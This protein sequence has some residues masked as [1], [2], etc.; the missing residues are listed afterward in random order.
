MQLYQN[1]NNCLE[2]TFDGLI[3]LIKQRLGLSN[4]E[5]TTNDRVRE[6]MQR[7]GKD[8]YPLSWLIIQELRAWRENASGHNIARHGWTSPQSYTES[9]A[10]KAY[11][12]P[13]QLGVELHIAHNDP[14]MILTY[15][16][17]LMIMGMTN[18]LNFQ[19]Q[20]APGTIITVRCEIPDTV[21]IPIAS[22][23]DVALPNGIELTLGLVL[24]TWVGFFKDVPRASGVIGEEFKLAQTG[25]LGE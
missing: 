20:L 22:T 17:A 19:V 21:S 2:V 13:V 14:R 15:S 18:A 10:S 12:F 16:E 6:Q 5:I 4:I 23:D 3:G 24:Y 25:T 1:L 7:K 8:K 9:T 11:L